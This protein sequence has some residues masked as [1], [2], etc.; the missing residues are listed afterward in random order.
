MVDIATDTPP[1]KGTGNGKASAAR[2]TPFDWYAK[3]AAAEFGEELGRDGWFEA[4]PCLAA[5]LDYA[6]ER[7]WKVFPARIK[8]KEK[9]SWLW[10]GHIPGAEKWG[11]TNDFEQLRTNFSDPTYRKNCLVGIPTGAVNEIIVL[12]IDTKAGGHRHDGNAAFEA[13]EAKHGKLPD[14]LMAVSPSGSIH[15]YFKHPGPNVKITT[16]AGHIGSI[17][18]PGVDIRGDGGMVVAPPSVRKDGPYRWL[19]NLPI[20]EAPAWLLQLVTEDP[21]PGVWEQYAD[22]RYGNVSFERVQAAV[23]AIPFK[24]DRD[25]RVKVGHAIKHAAGEDGFELFDTWCQQSSNY[26]PDKVQEK[27][28]GFKPERIS[29]GT[30]KF[31]ADEAKPG[32]ENTVEPV[33]PTEAPLGTKFDPNE[34]SKE[35]NE[36]V[37]LPVIEFITAEKLDKHPV[38]EIE[39]IAQ[40]WI[41][42]GALNGMF[43]DG[44][45]GKDLTLMQLAFAMGYEKK[46]LGMDVK[47][48]RVL[49]INVE[50]PAKPVLRWRQEKIKEY[51]SI[52]LDDERPDRL[53]IVPMLGKPTILATF[54]SKTGLVE[55]TL[56]FES[57]RRLIKAYQ[58]A[59]TIVGNRVNIFSVNQNDDAQAR[60]CLGLLNSLITD[61]GTTVI[62]PSHVSQR[63]MQAGADGTSGSVQWNNG[64]RQRLVLRRPDKDG[65]EIEDKHTRIMEVKKANW[66]PTG[67]SM[68]LSWQNGLILPDFTVVGG[69]SNEEKAERAKK[70]KQDAEDEF[71]R[72]LIKS[73]TMKYNLSAHP[74]S[75]NNAAKVFSE[76]SDCRFKGKKGRRILTAAMERLF[77]QK[78]IHAVPYGPPSDETFRI[79]KVKK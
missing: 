45:I 65:D 78:Q 2:F 6:T 28:K 13:L 57:F 74:A 63:G 73:E 47:P 29:F 21:K 50:D 12:E 41:V 58:P 77:D 68:D 79:E 20:A 26:N 52:D 33:T 34:Q 18:T 3:F 48:G 31:L 19:N 16:R 76:N 25:F 17:E 7:G 43:G 53:R 71:L 66:G 10:A 49:Y 59:L 40:D 62:M 11:M 8:G 42:E 22:S 39:W 1:R 54:N 46:W 38:K 55:P 56:L 32:W 5:A 70:E 23:N 14:T 36:K 72:M 9:L 35:A 75:R 67:L 30:L 24:E 51:L 4:T 64:V 69:N 44:G 27:W 37:K 60:Q 15:R 61:F